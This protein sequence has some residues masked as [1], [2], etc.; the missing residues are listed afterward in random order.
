MLMK[1]V[2]LS[3]QENDLSNIDS[4]SSCIFHFSFF[5]DYYY[6]SRLCFVIYYIK[7]HYE[8]LTHLGTLHVKHCWENEENDF[9]LRGSVYGESTY[10]GWSSG[11]NAQKI[12]HENL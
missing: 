11:E 12:C 2:I 6:Y 7:Y 5:K 8:H 3:K 4:Y 10:I 1:F 9:H